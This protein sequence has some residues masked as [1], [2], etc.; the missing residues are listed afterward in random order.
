MNNVTYQSFRRARAIV[1]AAVA[2]HGGV[3][4]VDIGAS[5]A[6]TLI[7]EGHYDVPYAVRIYAWRG[8]L[9]MRVGGAASRRI[10]FDEN[11]TEGETNCA[12]GCG[13][14]VAPG[15]TEPAVDRREVLRQCRALQRALP[16]A[17]LR[18][19]IERA[20]TLRWIGAQVANR[21]V[22]DIIGFIDSDG[23]AVSLAI[24]CGTHLLARWE[25]LV[26]H[27]Q[28]GD[29]AEWIAF[30][31]YQA[32]DG[33]QIPTRIVERW[34]NEDSAETRD[35][36]L[37]DIQSGLPLAIPGEATPESTAGWIELKAVEPLGRAPA[38]VIEIAPDL[39]L[40]ELPD[41]DVKTLF[42]VF[43][44]YVIALDAPLCSEAGEAILDAIRARAPDKSVR[45]A[46]FS[47]HHPHYLGGLRPFVA[48][49]ATLV[50]TP[51]NVGLLRDCAGRRYELE[52]DR[53]QRE[54]REAKILAVEKRHVFADR[55]HTLELHDIGP[56]TAHTRE[57]LVYY[58]PRLHLL[59]EGDL[60]SFP[61]S[62]EVWCA[63]AATIGLANAIGELGL[64]VRTIIQ[65]WPL[66]GQ[67]RTA[68]LADLEASIAAAAGKKG[69]AP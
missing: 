11:P 45:Y 28:L 32:V 33:L 62:G 52:P 6:G 15:A 18:Q 1:D 51:G 4:D 14:Y 9:V 66:R 44:E 29:T 48:E 39:F 8:S 59:V 10:R 47:H 2:R 42:A 27:P 26:P 69:E 49:G 31:D 13:R 60:A 43:D 12:G 55:G 65:T 54:P 34:L 35:I 22:H 58:F 37:S 16:H 7:D 25:R 46:V 17:V 64:D 41:E 19:A 38:T 3:L 36:T 30:S 56:A 57:F 63:R 67:K 23:H 24:D 40:V 61:A 21:A 5:F 53:L 68:T 50:T 20:A